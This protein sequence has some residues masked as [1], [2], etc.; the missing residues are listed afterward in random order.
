MDVIF[1]CPVCAGPI[2]ARETDR[3][4]AG[5][6]AHCTVQIPVPID[7]RTVRQS[8]IM[9]D[10]VM[11]AVKSGAGPGMRPRTLRRLRPL[12]SFEELPVIARSARVILPAM[13]QAAA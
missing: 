1:D 9:R 12:P 6:C 13:S 11:M 8:G 2:V 10:T 7:A 3:A 5:G 4:A